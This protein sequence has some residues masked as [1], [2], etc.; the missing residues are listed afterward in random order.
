M[1]TG[2][3]GGYS[4]AARA[5]VL[6]ASMCGASGMVLSSRPH[7]SVAAAAKSVVSLKSALVK[8]EEAKVV[9]GRTEL[10]G[11]GVYAAES[12]DAGTWVCSYVGELLTEE[13][14]ELRYNGSV[15]G[16]Y[17]FRI[18][19]KSKT[20]AG[21]ILDAQDSDHFSRYFNHAQHGNLDVTVNEIERRI[22]FV[23]SA[24]ISK[25]EEMVFDY[26]MK[27]WRSR[28]GPLP[29]SD[30]RDYSEAAWAQRDSEEQWLDQNVPSSELSRRFPLPRGTKLP[31]TP[32]R[33]AE[34]QAALI[35]EEPRCREALLRSL[36]YFGAR[37]VE[38]AAHELLD[39][40][41]GVGESASRRTLRI[42]SLS[43]GELAEAAA[44]CVAEA[45]LAGS[46]LA[47][48]HVCC[49]DTCLRAP[50]GE[51]LPGWVASASDELGLIRKWRSTVP[52][53]ASLRHDAIAI[54]AHLMCT[55]PSAH[56]VSTPLPAQTV[57]QIVAH[58]E[59][60]RDEADKRLAVLDARAALERHA[61]RARIEELEDTIHCW[62]RVGEGLV[63]E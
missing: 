2:Q 6:F 48:A 42:D 57:N 45:E 59:K 31:L 52:R 55:N 22:D 53:Q 4:W 10:K 51:D 26:G 25:G 15:S 44:A 61:P 56:E 35:L 8:R 1:M 32:L 23:A 3:P 46:G 54:V 63:I 14:S 33:P 20:S 24:P 29:S 36:E 62:L 28:D 13:E 19:D 50:R 49:E 34:L 58:L 60:H 9:V 7:V 11:M 18:E 43:I 5:V 37:R 12:I 27:Y 40:P 41:Y 17:M 30:S 47:D 16:D 39:V 21:A 38:D